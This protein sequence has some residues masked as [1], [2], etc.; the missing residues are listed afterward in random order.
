MFGVVARWTQT[1]LDGGDS[2]DPQEWPGERFGLPADGV[3]SVAGGGR[4]LLGFVL[5]L[6]ASSLVTALIVRPDYASTAVMQTF[7]LASVLVWVVL[8]VPSAALF[9]FTPGMVAVGVR[10]ARVDGAASLG[11]WRAIVRCLLTALLIPAAMRDAD[12]RGLHDRASD[13][14]V[15]RQR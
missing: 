9:G 13:T 8:T 12:G 2:G 7:N 3:G 11:W 4:R 15:I 6:V 10:V 5:D 14:V 1:W